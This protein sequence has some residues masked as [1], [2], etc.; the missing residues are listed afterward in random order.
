MYTGI[1]M[2]KNDTL[3]CSSVP[4]TIFYVVLIPLVWHFWVW[5]DFSAS[6]THQIR[7]FTVQYESKLK[8]I[9]FITYLP[10]QVSK[11][12]VSSADEKNGNGLI[13][14]YIKDNER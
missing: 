12:L 11:L 4:I 3:G 13:T 10:V 6:I 1:T 14:F 5:K 2:G 7:G 9:Q 8:G